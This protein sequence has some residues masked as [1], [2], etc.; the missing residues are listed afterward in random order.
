MLFG[1]SAGGVSACVLA[2]SPAARG[3]FQ[4]VGVMSGPCAGTRWGVG[5]EPLGKKMAA[6]V[7][8]ALNVTNLEQVRDGQYYYKYLFVH[9]GQYYYKSFVTRVRTHLYCCVV[10]S[11]SSYSFVLYCHLPYLYAYANTMEIWEWT[12]PSI[13]WMDK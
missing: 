5:D 11:T 4:S 2:V 6:S 13:H 8:E 12:L 10:C 1:E 9:V 3:L 7:M